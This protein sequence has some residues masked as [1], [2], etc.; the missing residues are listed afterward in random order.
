MR[1][2]NLMPRDARSLRRARAGSVRGVHV[3][4]AVLAA[5]V[6][7]AT[8]W[9]IAGRQV[10]DRTAE[11]G[12]LE[13]AVA[14]AERRAGDG[15]AYVAFA[16]LAGN[17]VRTVK[18]LSATRFD[19]AHALREIGRVLPAD[20]WLTG[21]SGVSGAGEEP[22]TPSTAAAPNPVVT[23]LGCTRSQ[24]KVARLLARLRTIDGVRRVSLK[25][26]EK[27]DGE[28]DESCPANR[29]S[30]P[31]FAIALAFAVPG[32]AK[33]GVDATG[34]VAASAAPAPAA[35]RGAAVNAAA[36]GAQAAT[37]GGDG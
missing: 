17:R 14:A 18:K 33:D 34:Q 35:G 26:S 9:A 20:V 1:A 10:R 11:L 36:S 37:G 2:A 13:A 16:K 12:R 8:L 31:S 32:A 23:L 28:G 3:L 6:V 21:M 4:L 30:D 24:A 15:A 27:P 19:W 5:L 7:L 29:A 22:P 25:S